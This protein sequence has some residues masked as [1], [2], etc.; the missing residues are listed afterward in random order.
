M[1]T[2]PLKRLAAALA[3]LL[4]ITV[5]AACA[6]GGSGAGGRTPLQISYQDTAFP[7]LIDASGVLKG[8]NFDVTWNNLTGPAA[9]LQ[10]LYAGAIDLGHMGDT[11]LTIEQANSKTPWT[12]QNAPLEIVAGW[13]NNYDPAYAPLVTAVRTSAGITDPAQLRGHSWA[14]N[15][16]GYN[17]AQY[18]VSLVKAGLTPQDITPVQ[19]AYGA[20]SASAFNSGRTDV[21]SGAHGAILSAL[22]S[23]QARILYTDK[24]TGI[25]ALNVWTASRKALNDPKKNAALTEFFGRMSGFWAWYSDHPDQAKAIIAKQLKVDPAR[26]DFEYQV[27]SGSFWKFDDNLMAEEQQ[28]A[29]TLYDG[30]AISQLPDV[31]IGF[32]PRYNEAQKAIGTQQAQAYP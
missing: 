25:P 22:Q 9:N 13:R 21:Y 2:S 23:G 32:D 29:K 1:R 14:F 4:A 18:L 3:G 12:A 8:G 24:D 15:F 28:V 30:K 19:F 31:K 20:T 17:H 5:V 11:S 6:G 10:A 26:T 7:A 16:G 27:R